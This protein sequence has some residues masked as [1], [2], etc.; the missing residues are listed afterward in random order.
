MISDTNQNES[1]KDSETRRGRH[2]HKKR[3]KKRFIFHFDTQTFL[4]AHASA[5]RLSRIQTLIDDFCKEW[6]R[7]L[8][9][10]DTVQTSTFFLVFPFVFSTQ[11]LNN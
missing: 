5:Q 10:D 1:E 8:I 2:G 4:L 11:H 9:S 7:T 3:K 6:G